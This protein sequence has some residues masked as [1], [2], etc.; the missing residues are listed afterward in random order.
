LTLQ[1][2]IPDPIDLDPARHPEQHDFGE[3]MQSALV[4][5]GTFGKMHGAFSE[6]LNDEADRP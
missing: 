5:H 2:T 3:V 6:V 1:L 4:H